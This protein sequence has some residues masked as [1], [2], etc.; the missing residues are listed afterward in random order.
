MIGSLNNQQK[1]NIQILVNRM[2][3]KGIT[4]KTAQAAVLAIV[5]K[6]SNF[7]PQ[8]ENLNYSASRLVQV[9]P[10]RFPNINTAKP[11]EKKPELI[12][13]RVYG[14]RFGNNLNEGFKFRGRGFNQITFKDTYRTI[15]SKIGVDLVSS[16]DLLNNPQ[17]A[18]DA[19][20]V[21][22]LDR[23]KRLYPNLNINTI[24]NLTEVLNVFYNA[25]AGAVNKHLK[26]VT[27]G[28]AK[29]KAVVVDL[30]NLIE[31]NKP[32]V[33]GAGIG[34]GLLIGGLILAFSK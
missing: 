19:L 1:Q 24:N 21:Y 27:G 32:V 30:Y 23:I 31:K 6:E 16:P 15:G 28:Y 22:F 18:A 33:I 20:I 26:D 2:N 3:V 13:N 34:L 12:A 25:N 8:S 7:I 11:F 29:A 9:F 5:Q 17:V 4:S 14:G 10:S